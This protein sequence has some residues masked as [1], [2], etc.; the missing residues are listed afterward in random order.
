MKKM[1]TKVRRYVEQYQLLQKEDRLILGVSAGADSVCLFLILLLLQKE[2]A[3]TLFVVHVN[4]GIRGAEAKRDAEYVRSLCK[5]HHVPYE[6]VE[7]DVKQ[8][9]KQQHC[10]EEESGRYLRYQALE[11]ARKRHHANKI[12]VAH[13]QNDQAETVLFHLFRGSGLFG[14]SGMKP[15][16]GHLIRPLLCVTRE[17]IEQFLR[18]KAVLFCQ[19]STNATLQYTRNRMRHLVLPVVQQ[20]INQK[21]VQHI[22]ETARQL[23]Q[24][25]AYLEKEAYNHMQE[26]LVEKDGRYGLRI[27]PLQQYDCVLQQALIRILF[28]KENR[29]LHNYTAKHFGAIQSLLEKPVG[30]KITLPGSVCAVRDQD[31]LWLYEEQKRQS[32]KEEWE[33]SLVDAKT[34]R[35]LDPYH[36]EIQLQYFRKGEDGFCEV[37][38]QM[39]LDQQDTKYFDYDKIKN[40]LLLRT[41]KPGDFFQISERGGTKKVKSFL[42]DQ[43]I[44]RK[45]RDSLLLLADGKHVLWIIGKRTSEA[46]HVQEETKTILKVSYREEKDASDKT[47]NRR[48]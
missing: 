12:A 23:A 42:I 47:I 48:S 30:K 4:H 24:L 37:K 44:P 32:E 16:R 27:A 9:A 22:A 6:L 7:K 40:T 35:L 19:D 11:E 34:Y 8:F 17:E 33:L 15:Q 41:R 5:Q 46:Y 3:L 1:I 14:L 39:R 20:Q 21:A 28:E 45:E 38:K 43:K 31:V 36:A 13:H 26:V 10:S 2:Y 29:P 18:E 25:Q